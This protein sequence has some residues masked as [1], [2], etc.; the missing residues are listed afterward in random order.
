MAAEGRFAAEEGEG[1]EDEGQMV[2]P[3]TSGRHLVHCSV[4]RRDNGAKIEKAGA[5]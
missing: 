4:A 1:V 5:Q 3:V 2:Q